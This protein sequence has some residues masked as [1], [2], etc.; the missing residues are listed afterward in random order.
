MISNLIVGTGIATLEMGINPFV[1]LCGRPEFPEARL[2][3]SYFVRGL[4]GTISRF[5]VQ[6]PI[7]GALGNPR[8]LVI[9]QW[10]YLGLAVLCITSMLVLYYLPLPDASYVPSPEV[11]P[12]RLLSRGS[13]EDLANHSSGWVAVGTPRIRQFSVAYVT[14]GFGIAT[15]LCYKP[16]ESSIGMIEVS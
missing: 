4:G 15:Q 3:F 14:L 6:K 12:M 13:D 1:A 10:E 11:S 5:V 8:T 7:F 9:A 16:V 2:N